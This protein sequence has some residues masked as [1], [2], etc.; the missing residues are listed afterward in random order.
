MTS[1]EDL[2]ALCLVSRDFHEIAI[3]FLYKDVI[4]KLGGPLDSRLSG[5][6]N[7]FNKGIEYMRELNVGIAGD[8]CT[9]AELSAERD[10]NDPSQR[11]IEGSLQQAHIML[12]LL[13]E[14]FQRTS[15]P[16]QLRK[17]R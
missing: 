9:I 2:R 4:L 15:P 5:L 13:F 14:T 17:F 16:I 7:P 6:I 3:Q 12:K 8:Y 1:S 10:N 11:L